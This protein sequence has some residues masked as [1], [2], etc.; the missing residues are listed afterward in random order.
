MKAE[1]MPYYCGP[2]I[3]VE[4]C[5]SGTST[6]DPSDSAADIA[7]TT[8]ITSIITQGNTGAASLCI[9]PVR[10]GKFQTNELPPPI[11]GLY[12]NK[13]PALAYRVTNFL[14]VVYGFDSGHFFSTISKRNL[15]FSVVLACDP[16]DYG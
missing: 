7:A 10:F 12:N 16:F 3:P 4:H 9:H 15:P 13:F 11:R 1:H 2:C 5:P 8:L 14:W 6:D